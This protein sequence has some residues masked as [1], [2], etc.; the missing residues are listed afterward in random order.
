MSTQS[1]KALRLGRIMAEMGRRVNRLLEYGESHGEASAADLEEKARELSRGIMASALEAAIEERRQEAEKCPRCGCGREMVYKGDQVR[2]QETYVGRIEWRRGYYYCCHCRKGR[3]PLD[4]ALGMGGGQFSDGIQAGSSW[5]AAL[6]PFEAAAETFT[7]LLGIDM[8]GREVERLSEGRGA[9][10]E[11]R[12]A[13]ARE[14]LLSGEGI[15][16]SKPREKPGVWA[17]AL[18]AAKGRF[19]D[20]QAN[21]PLEAFHGQDIHPPRGQDIHPG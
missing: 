8:T 11:S 9:V 10:L 17:V 3:Y 18:D 7:Y 19:V 15:T 21:H 14:E 13:V 12:Q 16:D 5:L 4:E 2:H 20:G 1:Q 6:M